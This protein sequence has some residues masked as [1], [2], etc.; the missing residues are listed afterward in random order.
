MPV[1][2]NQTFF[3]AFNVTF[4]SHSYRATQPHLPTAELMSDASSDIPPI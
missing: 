1:N 3:F 2:V 4:Q